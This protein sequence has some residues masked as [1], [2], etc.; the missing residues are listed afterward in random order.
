MGQY[1]NIPTMKVTDK[2]HIRL[3]LLTKVKIVLEAKRKN[4]TPSD[5]VRKI[6]HKHFKIKKEDLIKFRKR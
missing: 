2:L 5:T 3:D 6:L 4:Q 1:V